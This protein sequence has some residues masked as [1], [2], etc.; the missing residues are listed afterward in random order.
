MGGGPNKRTLSLVKGNP[1]ERK[2]KK[3]LGSGG[4][5]G[6]KGPR[7]GEAPGKVVFRVCAS[8]EKPTRKR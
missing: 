2:K 6:G 4:K 8:R 7:K 5:G 3:G 1:P